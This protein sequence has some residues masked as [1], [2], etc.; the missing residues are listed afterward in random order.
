MDTLICGP[1][2]Y[3]SGFCGNSPSDRPSRSSMPWK[4]RPLQRDRD[5]CAEKSWVQREISTVR[6]MGGKAGDS[7][8]ELSSGCHVTICEAGLE[9]TGG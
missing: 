2:A 7:F 1:E 4:C 3:N 9:H 6:E 5:A 8:S